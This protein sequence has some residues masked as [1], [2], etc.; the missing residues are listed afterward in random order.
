MA[1]AVS[2]ICDVP[3]LFVSQPSEVQF[4]KSVEP[5]IRNAAPY[6]PM[7]EK[8]KPCS[9]ILFKGGAVLSSGRRV[10]LAVIT[11]L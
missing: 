2:R 1:T 11:L 9:S 8:R 6:S 7:M 3:K 4:A 10:K 5:S